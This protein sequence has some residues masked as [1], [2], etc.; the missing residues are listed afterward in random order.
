M[1]EMEYENRR[2][3]L[4]DEGIFFDGHFFRNCFGDPLEG[5]PNRDN[6]FQDY[7]NE[8]N[9]KINEFNMMNRENEKH[10]TQSSLNLFVY[11]RIPFLS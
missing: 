11:S 7:L 10:Q 9:R 2:N 5:H 8:E 4:G 1:K 6:M 3:D